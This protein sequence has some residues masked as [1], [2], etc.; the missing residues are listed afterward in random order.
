[1]LHVD[2]IY[3]TNKFMYVRI[4]LKEP[5]RKKIVEAVLKG[6]A[7]GRGRSRLKPNLLEK[8]RYKQDV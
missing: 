2:Y 4:K 6:K 8:S 1:M 5:K 7:K 3:H